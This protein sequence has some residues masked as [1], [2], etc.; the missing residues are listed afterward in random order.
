MKWVKTR[1][2]N[3]SVAVWTVKSGIRI[4]KHIDWHLSHDFGIKFQ[5]FQ[6]YSELEILDDIPR[7]SFAWIVSP[8]INYLASISLDK[9]DVYVWILSR[10]FFIANFIFNFLPYRWW[11]FDFFRAL[12]LNVILD[13][14][15]V[16]GTIKVLHKIM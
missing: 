11:Y 2:L 6:L 4:D 5:S 15:R 9:F 16:M 1:N 7:K 10:I 3:L 13:R 14:Y 12:K 8:R